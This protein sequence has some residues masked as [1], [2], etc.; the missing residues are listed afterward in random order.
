MAV[1]SSFALTSSAAD[2]RDTFNQMLADI[3]SMKSG[4][5]SPITLAISAAQIVNEGEAVVFIVT[6]TGDMTRPVIVGWS[7]AGTGT[8]PVN[9]ADHAG[10]VFPAAQFTIPANASSGQFTIQS[11]QDSDVEP[12]ETGLATITSPTA[13]VVINAASAQYTFKNDDAAAGTVVYGP[14]TTADTTLL[15]AGGSNYRIEQIYH[16]NRVAGEMVFGCDAS[17]AGFSAHQNNDQRGELR[18]VTNGVS[19]SH[20]AGSGGYLGGS[21]YAYTWADGAIM[22]VEV[23]GTEAKLLDGTTPVKTWTIQPKGNFVRY[24]RWTGSTADSVKIIR[25]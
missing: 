11:N 19:S 2:S 20:N 23:R 21:E 6:R 12:N 8:S 17:G 15:D 5:T 3:A 24:V 16:P 18:A 4:S 7:T 25:L 22:A 14:E 1:L 9:A 13:N 10:G